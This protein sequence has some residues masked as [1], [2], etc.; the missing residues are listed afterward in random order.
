MTGLNFLRSFYK[1][2]KD[3][4][5][6]ISYEDLQHKDILI[7][8]KRKVYTY[9]LHY[10]EWLI[11]W[12]K[13]NADIIP[14]EYG[15]HCTLWSSKWNKYAARWFRKIVTLKKAITY[16]RY[17]YIIWLDSDI[18]CKK[19]MSDKFIQRLFGKNNE[20]IYHLGQRRQKRNMGI[21][22]GC[23]GFS[24]KLYDYRFLKVIFRMF[25][26]GDFRKYERWDDSYIFNK[27]IKQHLQI[28]TIDL[29]KQHVG[30]TGQNG[31]ISVGPFANFLDHNKGIHQKECII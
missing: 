13:Q 7:D 29:I 19:N 2:Q 11:N 10:D 1:I 3:G 9:N 25:E 12:V 14:K 30:G 23:I 24:Q 6:L 4:D 27:M 26:N 28:P 20:V 21:E 16:S 22:S 5:L 17:N 15:G 8:L 18:V 31:P